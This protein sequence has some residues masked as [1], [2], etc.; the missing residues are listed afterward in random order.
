M[1]AQGSSNGKTAE[2]LFITEKTVKFH[3]TNIY[4]KLGINSRVELVSGWFTRKFPD[5]IVEPVHAILPTHAA[6]MAEEAKR[7]VL[8]SGAV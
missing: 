5:D 3:L 6:A 1:V 2:L 7:K 4:K 8:P